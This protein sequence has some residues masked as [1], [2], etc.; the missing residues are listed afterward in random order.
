MSFRVASPRAEHRYPWLRLLLDLYAVID[1]SVA[2]A[3]AASGRSPG[4]G[5]GCH[6]CCHQPIPVTPLEAAGLHWYTHEEMP[7]KILALLQTRA[8]SSHDASENASPDPTC[9]FLVSGS[10]SVYAVR[11]V[12]CRRYI[13]LGRR[14][15]DREDAFRTRPGD[16][17]HPSR[18]ALNAGYAHTLPYYAALG[19]SVPEYL[20]DA[21]IPGRDKETIFA[22][23]AERSV[24]LHSLSRDILRKTLLHASPLPED[25]EH[26]A[27]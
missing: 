21:H 17:L 20:P 10:C 9:R 16:M 13:V 4:C 25:R 24:P 14:C 7:G 23:M 11:P 6:G 27:P 22:F 15:G 18:L 12:A 2:D 1:K 26:Q 19:L 5:R 8:A 3:V